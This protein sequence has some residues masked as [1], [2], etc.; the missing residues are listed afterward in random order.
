M[1]DGLAT[2]QK[3][4]QA[5]LPLTVERW[6]PT[7]R[8]GK[9]VAPPPQTPTPHPSPKRHASFSNTAVD[10]VV[11]VAVTVA[12]TLRHATTRRSPGLLHPPPPPQPLAEQALT[13]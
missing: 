3:G 13:S 2:E 10:A 1:N 5:T 9:G 7:S 8:L 6:C 12:A 4:L 11:A